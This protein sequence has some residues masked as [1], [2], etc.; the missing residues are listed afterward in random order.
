MGL[1]GSSVKRSEDG[2]LLIGAGQYVGDVLPADALHASFVRSVVP[3][4]V[5]EGVRFDEARSVPGVVAIFTADDLDLSPKPPAIPALEQAMRRTSLAQDRIRYVGEPVAV[6]LAESSAAAADGAE[7]VE[8]EVTPL[9]AVVGLESASRDESLL[10]P[11]VGTNRCFTLGADSDAGMF[12]DCE[13]VVNLEFDNP[14]LSAAPIEPRAAVAHWENDAGR[15]RLTQW[16]CTQFPHRAKQLL[17]SACEVDPADVKVVTPEVGGGFGAKSG[18]YPEDIVVALASRTIG[19]PVCWTETRSESMLNLAHGRGIRLNATLGGDRQGNLSAYRLHI[20]QDAGA[21]PGIGA[22]LPMF[23]SMMATGPYSIDRL[24]FSAASYVTNT[25][26]MGAYR[27]AGRPEATHGI[28]RI[29]DYYA[30]EIGV[31]AIEIRR[32]NFIPEASFPFDAPSGQVYDSGAYAA[33]LDAVLESLDVH[34]LR[35]EQERRRREKTTGTLLGIGFCAY[36]EITNPLKSEEFGKVTIRKDG[37]ALVLTG[38]SAHGQGHHT[39]FAQVASDVLGIAFENV[40]VRHGNTDE[41]LRGGGTGG[42]RSLQV[43]GS[44]VHSASESVV[45]EGRRLASEMLEASPADIV[46]DVQEGVFTVS[47]SPA[48][49]ISWEDVAAEADRQGVGLTAEVDFKPSGATFPFGVHASLVEIDTDTGGVTVVRHVSCDDAGVIVNPT[50]VDGQVHGGVAGGIAQALM[51][52]FRYADDGTPMT[53]NF[54]DYGIVSAAELPSFER[55]AQETPTSLNPLGVKGIGEAGTI[56]AMPAV[57]N[58][59]VDA[60]SHLGVRHVE[61]PVTAERIWRV[62]NGCDA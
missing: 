5:L 55:I 27:G 50:I 13:V 26:P 3:H 12:D 24:E 59:V 34:D 29:I 18:S 49:R 61:I 32:Q 39:T 22:F 40:E 37:S 7:L 15:L 11:E 9:P 54:M 25:V 33:A 51:E 20:D 45:D 58:A 56:G 47:G 60:L 35:V 46:L 1:L 48:V 43:G 2:P 38:S 62:L 6:V 14:R 10:Y 36:V 44:A 31:D 16:S 30:A 53:A 21:Y 57:Q 41:V 8:V 17:A 4:G 23:S 28:E 42:S 19:R 52:E